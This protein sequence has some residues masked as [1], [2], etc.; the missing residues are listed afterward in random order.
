VGFHVGR[1]AM[2]LTTVILGV[3]IALAGVFLIITHGN[4]GGT[5]IPSAVGIPCA[6]GN[7]SACP[8]FGGYSIGGIVLIAGLPIL[9]R[10]LMSPSLA[11]TGSDT[12]Q[13]M[14]VPPQ[15]LAAMTGLTP[16]RPFP[17]TP[18]GLPPPAEGTVRYCVSC[19]QPNP[20][21][22]AFCNKCGKPMPKPEQTEASPHG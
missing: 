11:R 19:G 3:L 20:L 8:G 17:P 22:S 21:V 10:G 4:I 14:G 13:G 12:G 6:G 9:L 2:H 7:S 16:G 18:T 15:L 5:N 1:R